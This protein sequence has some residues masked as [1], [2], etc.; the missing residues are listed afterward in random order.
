[1]VTNDNR[2]YT[3][4]GYTSRP[5][6]RTNLQ[7]K[8]KSENLHN[9]TDRPADLDVNDRGLKRAESGVVFPVVQPVDLDRERGFEFHGEILRFFRRRR[10]IIVTL[11]R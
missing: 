11:L 2:S 3:N 6:G 5:V 9:Q 4:Y 7:P 8:P 1:M 10:Q